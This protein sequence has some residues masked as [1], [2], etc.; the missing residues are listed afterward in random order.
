MATREELRAGLARSKNVI[1]DV[2]RHLT[3]KNLDA[4]ER[5][6]VEDYLRIIEDAYVRIIQ[7]LWDVD[8]AKLTKK[9]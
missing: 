2:E 7:K 4:N 8:P 9:E 6:R 1:E 3:E 5:A